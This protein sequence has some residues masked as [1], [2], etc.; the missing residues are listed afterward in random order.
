VDLTG[1]VCAC[2]IGDRVYSGIGGQVDFMRGAVLCPDGIAILALPSTG[3]GGK[4]SRIVGHLKP[5]A[6]VTLT[7]GHVH[8]IVTEYGVADLY[9]RSLSE[10]ARALIRIAHPDF[11][12][13]LERFAHGLQRL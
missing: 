5:G 13:E 12:D 2:S 9:A 11:R 3:A 10:R 4:F 6:M 1:Q 7:Q 8:Y